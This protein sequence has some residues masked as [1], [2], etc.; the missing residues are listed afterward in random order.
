MTPF[1]LLPLPTVEHLQQHASANHLGMVFLDQLREPAID[2]S[3]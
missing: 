3:G 1:R 2:S